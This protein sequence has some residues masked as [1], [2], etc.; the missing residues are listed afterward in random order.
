MSQ[1]KTNEEIASCIAT[2]QKLL[3]DTN[4]LFEIPEAQRVALFKV[5]VSA[6]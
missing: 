1:L 2:I 5:A 3:E 4:Q 6:T